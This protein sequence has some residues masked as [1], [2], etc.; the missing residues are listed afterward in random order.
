MLTAFRIVNPNNEAN[1]PAAQL[2]DDIAQDL[3][4]RRG[5]RQNEFQAFLQPKFDLVSN[6]VLSV[7]VLARWHHRE[8]G[9]LAPAAFIQTM[10]HED[11]L[12]DLL[13]KLLDQGLSHQ[14][15]LHAKGHRLGFAFNLSLAQLSSKMLV[16]HL[17]TRLQKHPLALSMVTFEITEDGPAVASDV[18][19]QNILRL[20]QLG[21]RLSLDDYG[22]GHSSLFRLCQLPFDEIKLAGE[23]TRKIIESSQHYSIARSTVSL[24]RELGMQL[25]VEGI[26]T[27]DQ[28]V[29]LSNMGVKIGQGYL[30][31]R[32]MSFDSLLDW[33]ASQKREFA[34]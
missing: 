34:A 30:C 14:T 15:E 13:C 1:Q 17:I 22:T 6:A 19:V 32:P 5:L 16:T 2:T 3:D 11:L 12:D 25:V 21:V 24:A 8:H 33:L 28:R 31:A 4:I 9:L 23:F 10:I 29:C 7:E 27:E 20:R 26:E 18:C